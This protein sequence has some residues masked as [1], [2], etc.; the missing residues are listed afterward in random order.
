MQRVELAHR[1]LKL[2][3]LADHEGDEV[4]LT[5]N[6]STSGHPDSL[7]GQPH[8]PAELLSQRGHSLRP[9]IVVPQPIV[10]QHALESLD[11]V[12]E[13]CSHILSPEELRVCKARCQHSLVA[14]TNRIEMSVIA[15]DDREEPV[16]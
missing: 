2:G 4:G 15:V 1:A 5:Q 13:P 8:V 14:F 3:E 12:F 16:L 10:E 7:F 11:F 9:R 6:R